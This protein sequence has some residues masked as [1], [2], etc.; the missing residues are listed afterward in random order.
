MV[1]IRDLNNLSAQ[2]ETL[3]VEPVKFG[4]ALTGNTEPSPKGKV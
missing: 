4:E 1:D 2:E 3:G